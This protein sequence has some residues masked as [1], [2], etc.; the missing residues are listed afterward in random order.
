MEKEDFRRFMQTKLTGR[1][2]VG[3]QVDLAS[4]CDK[5]CRSGNDAEVV[6]ARI[7]HE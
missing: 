6:K 2:R 4:V 1:A 5:G 3:K 7:T